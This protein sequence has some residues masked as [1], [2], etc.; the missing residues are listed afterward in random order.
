LERQEKSLRHRLSRA[1]A[2]AGYLAFIAK[3]LKNSIGSEHLCNACQYQGRFRPFGFPPRMNAR[4]PR[5]GSIERHRLIKL[6]FDRYGEQLAGSKVLHFAPE[7]Y[8]AELFKP[9]ASSYTSMDIQ[10]NKADVVGNIEELQFAD[11]SY[12]C[13]LCSHV[14]EHVDDHKAL[15]EMYRVLSPGGVAIILVPV[16][17]A[18][19]QTY[20]NPEITTAA[21]RQLHFGQP[22]HVRVYGADLR[23]R[24]RAAG[25]ELTEFTAKE[26][27]VSTYSLVRGDKVFV[28]RKPGQATTAS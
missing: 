24:I 3:Q 4:C 7:R 20:E 26:P 18:W 27:D 8:I 13:I 5:C 9:I 14:L 15:R 28:S 2:S 25:F 23:D 19:E 17:E 22:D 12:S 11:G 10:E 21:G 16:V 6:W 1:R